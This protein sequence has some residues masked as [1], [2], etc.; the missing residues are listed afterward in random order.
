[1]AAPLAGGMATMQ[2][3]DDD[4]SDEEIVARA[5]RDPRHFAPLYRRYAKPIHAFVLR[6]TGD[7]EQ[8]A[9]ITSQVFT[10]ALAALPRYR[11]GPF[12]GWIYAIARNVVIDSR[13][14]A[15]PIVP[16]ASAEMIASRDVAPDE[17]AIANESRATLM[18]ALDTLTETQRHIVLLRLSGLTGRE[19]AEEL[20]IGYTAMK[21]AQYR[22][23]LRLRQHLDPD[24][25]TATT[26]QT[27]PKPRPP[28]KEPG[29][30]T[31]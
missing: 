13:R 30:D 20:G 14:R 25:A 24:R 29:H 3:G 17:Q 31:H 27:L 7:P 6:R 22:A 4:V 1:M 9:D 15:K 12:R 28:R 18:A 8:A 26:Q 10:R 21:S 23:F 2:T 11:N 19:V 5:Q 16:M